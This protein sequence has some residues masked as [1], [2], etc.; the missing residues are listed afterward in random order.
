MRVEPPRVVRVAEQVLEASPSGPPAW[1]GSLSAT[2]LTEAEDC[3]APAG[4]VAPWVRTVSGPWLSKMRAGP[5]WPTLPS[6]SVAV[7]SPPLGTRATAGDWPSAQAGWP[8]WP[9]VDPGPPLTVAWP[10][11]RLTLV[12]N[13][14]AEPLTACTPWGGAGIV[15]VTVAG[16]EKFMPSSTL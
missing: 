7:R 4:P 2:F 6:G 13:P 10:P 16:A 8:A 14:K 5:Y 11:K 1:K 12:S 3:T 9:Q 15:M